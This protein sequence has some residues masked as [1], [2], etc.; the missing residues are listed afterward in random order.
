MSRLPDKVRVERFDSLFDVPGSGL[1][2][3]RFT[4]LQVVNDVTAP[5]EAAFELGDDGSWREIEGYVAHGARYKVFVN[6]LLRLTGRVELSDNPLDAQA[7]SV[8]RF[9]VRTKL[10]DAWYASA[11]EGVSVR[12]VSIKDF[13]LALYE[14]LGF[15]E[16]D[17]VFRG[18][19]G[20]DLLTGRSSTNQGVDGRDVERV[21]VDAARVRPPETIYAA[22]DR[23]LRRH[24]LMHWDSPDGRIVVSAPNDEQDP[25]YHLVMVRANRGLANNVLGGTRSRDWSGIPSAVSLYGV[26]GKR[27]TARARVSSV[28]EDEDVLAAGFYRPVTILAEGVKTR[29]LA[30]RAAARELS[31][32]S[33]QKDSF[34]VE[35]D[36]L[37]YWTGSDR[38]PWGVD[39]VA[40]IETDVAG[41]Q[42]GAYY[43]HRVQMR[44]DASRGDVTNLSLLKKGV[45]RL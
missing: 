21:K 37:S 13:L 25:L 28:A 36:G 18:S 44:R 26:G 19:V 8:V 30:D 2:F 11:D 32:R 43:L 42:V 4:S 45:W 33:K 1:V 24:G 27:G 22:A 9:T 15:V 6:D 38:I 14:P 10:Q 29:E 35:V 20:R 41:G 17:F 23:H 34:D 3:D 7:G 12:K 16:S 31:S 40:S 39:T 5:S